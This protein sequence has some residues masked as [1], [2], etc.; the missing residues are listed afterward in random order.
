MKSCSG[1][2]KLDPFGIDVEFHRRACAGVDDRSRQV[3]RGGRHAGGVNEL[4]AGVLS[5]RAARNELPVGEG[6]SPS[7]PARPEAG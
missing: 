2:V 3:T 6:G 7:S 5:E 1:G 4:A